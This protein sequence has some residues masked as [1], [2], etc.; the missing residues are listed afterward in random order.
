MSKVK[1]RKKKKRHTR[2]LKVI[3][4]INK[5][6]WLCLEGGSQYINSK[7]AYENETLATLLEITSLLFFF[8]LASLKPLAM[9]PCPTPSTQGIPI[10]V[11]ARW[12]SC[13]LPLE[14]K[15]NLLSSQCLSI[16]S[17][18]LSHKAQ[19]GFCEEVPLPVQLY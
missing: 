10:F 17:H 8:T 11:H 6:Y 1:K 13:R 5:T 14:A 12:L 7:R 16:K 19:E 15:S 3:H 18:I 4:R 2:L 9:L